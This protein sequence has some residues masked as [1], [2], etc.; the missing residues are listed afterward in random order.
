M[1]SQDPEM[2]AQLLVDRKLR[3]AD[4]QEFMVQSLREIP[5]DKWRHYSPEDT[6]RFW[7]LRLKELGLIKYSPQDFIDRNTDWSH[8]ASLKK[9]MG[10]TW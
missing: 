6:I 9:E 3:K 8:I 4:D 10:M 2:A 5:Y 1:V 7:A